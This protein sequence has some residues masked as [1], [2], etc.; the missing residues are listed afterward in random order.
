MRD[1]NDTREFSG[2]FGNSFVFAHH[3]AMQTC[4]GSSNSLPSTDGEPTSLRAPRANW[5]DDDDAE[6]L[7]ILLAEKTKTGQLSLKTNVFRDAA[8]AVN[9]MI[10]KGGPK[11]AKSCKGRWNKVHVSLY[12]LHTF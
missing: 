10:V 6:L 7:A 11:S 9:A 12:V 1:A 3:P 8:V 4:S 5:N 2:I